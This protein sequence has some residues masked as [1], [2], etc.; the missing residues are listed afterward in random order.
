[1]FSLPI[2]TAL[3]T[4]VASTPHPSSLKWDVYLQ[5]SV[6]VV[7]P[8][9]LPSNLSFSPTAFTLVHSAHHAILID[10]P[11]TFATTEKLADWI[12]TKIQGKKLTHIYITHGHGDHFFGLPILQQ[13]FPGVKAVTTQQ[14]IDHMNQQLFP[15]VFASFWDSLFPG[16]IPIPTN[17][18]EV[19][20]ALPENG[21][22]YI[23][24]TEKKH[25]VQAVKVGQ[26][27]TYNTT[28]LHIPSL[29]MVVT[30]DAVYGSCFQY[31]VDTNTTALR[32]QWL[33]ALDEIEGLKPKIVVP[34][35][36]QEGDGFGP[37]HLKDTRGYIDNWEREADRVGKK[38]GAKGREELVER[39]RKQYPER[40]GDF[41]LEVSVQEVFT[42]N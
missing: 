36:M 7:S 14:T 2:L 17:R 26:T 9:G 30:G 40:I 37:N 42:Q 6:P 10:A 34:S 3:F 18:T 5:P 8:P 22:F 19:I 31:L 39:V 13:K 27:D 38:G 20:D 28:I 4:L 15:D 21:I 32:S 24:D 29:D 25:V 16:A 1:M 35:H 23:D 12:K 33:S 11:V 41:I